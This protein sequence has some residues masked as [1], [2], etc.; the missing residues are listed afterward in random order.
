M[1]RLTDRVS[2]PR[3]PGGGGGHDSGCRDR[4]TEGSLATIGC[5]ARPWLAGVGP[6]FVVEYLA[7]VRV[8]LLICLLALIR[9]HGL[10]A[11]LVIRM[12]DRLAEHQ[13]VDRV[14]RKAIWNGRGG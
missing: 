7:D 8:N 4:T 2:A 3:H 14:V 11:L 10:G 1:K 12:T 13:L 9:I 5:L 6:R